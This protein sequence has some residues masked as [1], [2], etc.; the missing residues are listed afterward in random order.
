MSIPDKARKNL[1]KLA[2]NGAET[3]QKMHD[4]LE[5]NEEDDFNQMR[6][7]DMIIALSK[8]YDMIYELQNDSMKLM[9]DT[10]TEQKVLSIPLNTKYPSVVMDK[11]KGAIEEIVAAENSSL[12]TV[13][14]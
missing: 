14:Q 3:L 12:R 11:I 6:A 7:A 8:S 10:I 4:I 9:A 13:V 2:K 1:L 5:Q